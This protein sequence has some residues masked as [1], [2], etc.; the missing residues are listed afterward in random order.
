MIYIYLGTQERAFKTPKVFQ[1]LLTRAKL[2]GKSWQNLVK[3]IVKDVAA[4]LFPFFLLFLIQLSAH[5]M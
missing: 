1:K 3:K 4:K 2:K 5:I